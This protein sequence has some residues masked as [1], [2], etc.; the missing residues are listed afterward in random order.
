MTDEP[1]V[2]GLTNRQ[3]Q[4]DAPGRRWVNY[5]RFCEGNFTLQLTFRQAGNWTTVF[6]KP[7]ACGLG[8]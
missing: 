4:A 1:T 7:A 5:A 3:D 8:S 6:E 2:T